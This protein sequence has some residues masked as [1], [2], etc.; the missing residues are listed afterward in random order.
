MHTN[1]INITRS[2][3][4]EASPPAVFDQIGNFRRWQAWSPWLKLDPTAKSSYAGPPSGRGATLSFMGNQKVGEWK[5]TVIET[6]GFCTIKMKL[7]FIEPFKAIY[8]V[9]FDF[10]PEGRKTLVSWSMSDKNNYSSK[11]V[12]LFMSYDKMFGEQFEKG[13]ENLKKILETEMA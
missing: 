4:I 7:E 11:S 5:M 6:S 1:N 3:T 13:L 8:D 10:K 2:A 12:G 9:A